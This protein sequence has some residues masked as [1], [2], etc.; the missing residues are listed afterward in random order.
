MWRNSYGRLFKAL[1][2]AQASSQQPIFP[3]GPNS[4][5]NPGQLN[6]DNATQASPK[7]AGDLIFKF[8]PNMDGLINLSQSS[9]PVGSDGWAISRGHISVTP[10][11]ASFA[12]PE[13]TH[14]SG[15]K[16]WKIKL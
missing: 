14:G 2:N 13:Q 16:V 5:S 8:A 4:L 10:L 9:L 15:D 12:E 6:G 11:R 7:H 1:P 3:A